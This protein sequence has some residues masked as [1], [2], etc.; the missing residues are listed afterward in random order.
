MQ[1]QDDD[2]V[3]SLVD[4]TLAQPPD[5]RDEYLKNA[6]AGNAELFSLVHE[7]VRW[8]ERMRG[9]L[10]DP[11]Y[12][13]ALA[14]PTFQPGQLLEGRFRIIREVAEG[15]MG[16]VYE[17]MDERLER[18]V[19][20][21]CA[22][23]GFRKRLPPEV[24]HAS[25]ISHPNVC[26]IF[27]IYTAATDHG[28]IEFFTMEFLDGET[29]ADRIR[30]GPVPEAESRAIAR[31]ICEGLAEAHRSQVIHGDLK[32]NNVI[33]TRSADEIIRAVITDFGLARRPDAQRSGQSGEMGGT[34]DYMAPELW[35][36]GKATVAS[37]I[38]ALGVILYEL[39][40]G[41]QPYDSSVSWET[42][43]TRKPPLVHGKWD[44]IFQRCLDPDPAGRFASANEIL[45]ALAPSH[46]GRWVLIA[47]AAIILAL[48][49]GLVTYQKVT[50]PKTSVRLM[51]S[52]FESDANTSQFTN[53]LR[54][55]AAAQ[56]ARIRGNG[57][58][59]FRYASQAATHV[60]YVKLSRQGERISLHASIADAHSGR[61]A[62]EWTASYQP[63]QLPYVPA[64]LAG[65]V[66]ATFRVPPLTAGPE[67]NAAAKQDYWNGVWY[68]RQNSTVD[69]AL[70][71]LTRAVTADPDSPFTHA[72]LAE[73][74][75]FE[76][77]QTKDE[78]WL[79]RAK[80]SVD[81]AEIF[82]ADI[83]PA[84]RVEG[85]LDYGSGLYERA[86]AEF[87]RAIELDPGTATAYI[88]MGK[89]Y[90]DSG[91][92]DPALAAFDKAIEVEPN[93]YRTYQNLAA[94]YNKRSEYDRAIQYYRRAVELAP[95]E[96][97]PHFA[98]GVGYGNSG[99]YREAENE[100][101]LSV[102]LR[103][104][105]NAM[106]ALGLVLMD[107]GKND[108]AI[109]YISRAV[110]LDPG[111]YLWWMNLG[112]ACRMA[113]RPA[114]SARA[115]RRGLELAEADMRKNPRSGYVRSLVAFLCARLGDGR[116]ADSEIAQALQLSPADADVH[117][118]AAAT[119][120]ALG[121]RKDTLAVLN[122]SPSEVIADVSR[123]PDMADL[124]RD[125]RFLHLLAS[126]QIK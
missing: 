67:V 108:E 59:R 37:D 3:M 21:K 112:T 61:N 52:P 1:A 51:I 119:Y 114:E 75:W 86:V 80:E 34:P 93:Y 24:R 106:H 121:R 98:L 12:R 102:H 94:F 40:A 27:E 123:W 96:P 14:E 125:S 116:R 73:A 120:E 78:A 110:T 44:P 18:R 33:L 65:F 13:S 64:A 87:E 45:E 38:Y 53:D 26:K 66:T 19:A 83:A 49:S 122:T 104:T 2:M 107:Q 15:G 63:G 62:R 47:A 42:R 81:Q 88:W 30:R 97:D 7:Y 77:F 101:R 79:V 50:A 29:L 16:V 43:L 117:W 99:Q 60:L 100:L 74:Q 115:Y 109:S 36:G 41:A 56:L 54:R 69:V 39:V 10:L 82:D 4:L 70:R 8:E 68:T 84:H 9:F 111:V 5:Q 48:V 55:G 85:Y 71:L 23:A 72:R 17:A 113:N 22:K 32:S 103:E 126:R 89:A 91:E 6:C 25:E 124:R 28:E 46:T 58:I 57:Q 92:L 11:L 76:Y 105:S 90:E 31:Q 20:I 118:M 95:N 35:K